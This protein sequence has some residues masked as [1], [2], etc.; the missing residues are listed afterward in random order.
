MIHLH[1][2]G[3]SRPLEG[4]RLV[5]LSLGAGLQ[6]SVLALMSA[7]G[8][9]PMLDAA[10]FADTGDEKRAT[11][12]HLDW[13]E[14][15]L[16]FPLIRLARPGPT[17]A[18]NAVACV[19]GPMEKTTGRPPYY[20]SQPHGMAPKQCNADFK[21]DVV[22][23]GIRALMETKGI[24]LQAGKPIVEQWVGFSNDE[25]RRM[26]PH[27]KKFIKCRWP[28][29]E[30]RMSRWD[31]EVWR[32]E[33]QIPVIP[34]SSCVFCPYQGDHEWS[35]MKAN[36]R[37]DDWQRATAFDEAIRPYFAGATGAAYVHR[38]CTPLREANLKLGEPDG[39][40]FECEGVCGV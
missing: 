30:A 1:H 5:V 12:R 22:T 18:E 2:D 29:I 34:K 35:E 36:L 14:A 4:A 19:A 10:F 3:L 26:A 31:C 15:Q 33:R 6:S 13:L 23:R 32:T 37:D 39:F 27:R 28:L 9:V 25:L 24:K 21:R 16:P 20:L 17:L 8:D 38:T 40:R 7:R 11:Y